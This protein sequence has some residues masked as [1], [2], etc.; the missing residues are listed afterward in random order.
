MSFCKGKVLI[1]ALPW[2]N[3]LCLSLSFY[4]YMFLTMNVK[5][6]VDL[7]AVCPF[8][9]TSICCTCIVYLWWSGGQFHVIII[10]RK[11]SQRTKFSMRWMCCLYIAGI[12]DLILFFIIKCTKCLWKRYFW[13]GEE[14]RNWICNFKCLSELFSCLICF[15]SFKQLF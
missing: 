2:K 6:Y 13:R 14:G 11:K 10:T 5:V 3:S 7:P 15:F 9:L 8:F 12:C 4:L 1:A